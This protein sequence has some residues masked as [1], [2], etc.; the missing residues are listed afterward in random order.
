MYIM[1]RL[2][3]LVVIVPDVLVREEEKKLQPTRRV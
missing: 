3:R 1:L 2:K